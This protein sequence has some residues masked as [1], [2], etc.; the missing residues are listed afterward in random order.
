MAMSIA[1]NIVGVV[2]GFDH[3]GAAAILDEQIVS[4]AS[5]KEI[6]CA[7]AKDLVALF[8]VT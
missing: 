2:A 6:D 8:G 1:V 7:A 3:G 4:V 5:E